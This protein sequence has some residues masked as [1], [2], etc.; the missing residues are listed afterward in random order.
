MVDLSKKINLA[1]GNQKMTGL[2][3]DALRYREV[4]R[5]KQLQK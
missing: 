4:S 2:S 3:K 1:L 5:K